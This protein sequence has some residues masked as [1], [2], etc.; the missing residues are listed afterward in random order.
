YAYF[1]KLVHQEKAWGVAVAHQKE[2]QAETILD[3]LL[4]GAG[5]RGLSGLRPVQTLSFSRKFPPLKVWRPLLSYSRAQLQDYLKIHHVRWRE[6][7]SN[8]TKQYRRNQIRHEVLPFLSRWNPRLTEVLA[9][10]GE[11]T[12]AEDQ[13][14]QNLLPSVGRKLNSRWRGKSYFCSARFFQGL[15]LALQRRWVRFACEKLTER[16]RGL[17]FAHIE[18]VIRLW[19][20]G[21]SGPRDLGFGLSAGRNKNNGF[22]QWKG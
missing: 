13:Y 20:G 14:L 17:S 21:E 4:R 10:V 7:Q 1:Q 5:S 18:E 12:A 6:D 19:E 11:I 9:R 16:A 2:D 3:R 22:L 8:N 15:P